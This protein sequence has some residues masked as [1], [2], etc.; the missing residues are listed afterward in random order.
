LAATV[1]IRQ[2]VG[3]SDGSPGS[4]S[5]DLTGS[6]LRFQTAD[7]IDN[8]DETYPIPIPA[9]GYNYSYWKH[10][11][12][13]IDSAPSVKINNIRHYS[14]GS[15]GY[16]YGSGGEVR[17]GNRDSGDHGCP[18]DT[19]YEVA[20]GTPSTTGHSIEDG[21]N[22]HTYYNTQTTKTA[23]IES[24]TDPGVVIDSTDHTGTGKSKAIVLQTRLD[25]AANGALSGE[26]TDETFSFKYDEI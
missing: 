23:N 18:M 17:R 3:G 26:Q 9:A 10:V 5:G 20:T 4:E 11:Y 24:D 19:N 8:A 13:S 2:C 1:T 16:T 12:L 15:I 7:Q 21:S 14:D 25:T 6:T 22:G